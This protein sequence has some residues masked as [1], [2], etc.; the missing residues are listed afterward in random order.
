MIRILFLV[1]TIISFVYGWDDKK[2]LKDNL[3]NSYNKMK[4]KG[5]AEDLENL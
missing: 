3:F 5:F 1:S 2:T 4:E